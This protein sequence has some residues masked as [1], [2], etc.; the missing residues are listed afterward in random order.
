MD[1]GG[2]TYREFLPHPGLSEYIKCFWHTHTAPGINNEYDILPDGYFDMLFSVKGGI[3]T[4]I[5]LT[6]IWAQMVTVSL[7]GGTGMFGVRFKPAALTGL[8]KINMKEMLNSSIDIDPEE[9]NLE[10]PLVTDSLAGDN[11]DM[12][13]EHLNMRFLSQQSC[14]ADSRIK[15]FFELVDRSSGTEPVE[16]I[17]REIGLS[18]RQVCRKVTGLIGIGA[19]EYSGIARFRDNLAS[20]AEGNDYD[21]FYDQSHLIKNFKK[22]TGMTPGQLNPSKNV[23]ILQ[24]SCKDLLLK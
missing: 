16:S 15:A 8:L 6:G 14:S 20:I 3:V 13:T 9:F 10:T 17:C 7:E 2:T 18:T 5:S 19:K 23:R 11:L 24:Y 12:L 1:K 21:G 4:G 22:Y